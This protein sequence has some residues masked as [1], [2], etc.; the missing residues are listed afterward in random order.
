M[1]CSP[2]H[3]S[4][5]GVIHLIALKHDFF[6]GYFRSINNKVDVGRLGQLEVIDVID[7]L[8][9]QVNSNNSLC[10]C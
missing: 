7:I 6:I 5:L 2:L 3:L 8:P 9:L 1:R 4:K 10:T